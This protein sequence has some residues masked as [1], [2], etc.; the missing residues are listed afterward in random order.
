[1]N[2]KP[3]ISCTIVALMLVSILSP[4]VTASVVYGPAQFNRTG[5]GPDLA[6]DNFSLSRT[7]GNFSLFIKNGDGVENLTSSALVRLNG[8]TVVKTNEFNQ[9]VFLISKNI[10]VQPTN[11]LEVEVRSIPGSYI[12]L[13][14]EDE[15]PVINILSPWDDAVSNGTIK[16]SGNVTDLNIT[17]LTLNYNGNISAIPVVYGNFSST[18][19]LTGISNITLSAVDSVDMLRSAT[20]LLDGDMLPES[21]ERFLGFDPQN[22]DSDSALTPENEAGN[23]IIDGYETLGGQLP[24]FVKSRIGADPFKNDTDNDGLTDYFELMK[25]GLLT[26]VRS[27]DSDGD[28]IPDAE[29]DPDNDNLT[30]LQEQNYGTDPLVSD[31]D[32]DTLP[33]GFEINSGTNPLLKD[34]DN[35]RL[36]DGSE[37]RLGTNPLNADTDGDGILD[38]D[39]VYSSIKKDEALGVGASITGKGDMAKN[40]SIYN[41]ASEVFTNVSALVSPVIDF[42]LNGTFE[43]AEISLPYD[44][45]RVNNPSNISL[46]YFNESLGTFTRIE[47]RADTVNHTVTGNTSHLSTFA[48]L[49]IPAWDALFEAPM[50]IGYGSNVTWTVITD[51][52]NSGVNW[53]NGSASF[54]PGLYRMN[55]S[56]W[57]THWSPK[58]AVTKCLDETGD[59]AATIPAWCNRGKNYN[60]PDMGMHVRYGS[61]DSP[62]SALRVRPGILEFMH[63]GG[64]IGVWDK[65]DYYGDNSADARY[66]LEYADTDGDGLPDFTETDGFRDG[67][68]NLYKTDP[69]NP[70]TDGDGLSDGE[71]A[72]VLVEISGKRYFNIISKPTLV[73]SDHDGIADPDEEEFGTK[74]LDPDYDKDGLNDGF[75]L[76]IG[77]DPLIQDTDNDEYGDFEEHYDPFYD[78]LVYEK[79]Y[80]I[81]EISRDVV[82]GAVLGEWGADNNDSVYYMAG[83]MLSGFIV[84]G[85]IRDI[86]AS[87]ARGDGLGT[88][89]N[90]LALIPGYG[91]A[92]KV[93]VTISKFVAKHPN[94]M[95]SAASFA[96]KYIDDSIGWIKASIGEDVV[97]N[98]N[99][100]GFSDD[101]IIKLF[102][103]IDLKRFDDILTNSKIYQDFPG[104]PTFVREKLTSGSDILKDRVTFDAKK[105]TAADAA[106]RSTAGY[107]GNLK[108]AYTEYLASI[109]IGG[110]VVIGV[111]HVNKG[112]PDY[113]AMVGGDTLKIVEAKARQSLTLGNLDRYIKPNKLTGAL[114]FNGDYVIKD[115]GEDYFKNPS[116]KKQF[117]LYLNGPNSQAIKNSLNLPASLPYEFTRGTEKIKG[118]IEIVVIAVNK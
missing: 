19:N 99:N 76:E 104:L 70:D 22:P 2:Y 107:L 60:V 9:N 32:K 54:L 63:Q 72:G 33:D 75:E 109:D 114:E 16:V 95:F 98:L 25:L 57:Y 96:L 52:R 40:L 87:I 30:N 89:L 18:V 39:E 65:D 80:S 34:T 77:T 93:S 82:L 38:G 21:Q 112:G 35:D 23:G 94:M 27:G 62:V 91:D 28:G 110:T 47:S 10:S 67:L 56:G 37:I 86:A 101:V 97:K 7:D 100:K 92:A 113:V 11:G 58:P 13:W 51:N 71:E 17:N 59:E 105:M 45:Q 118:T 36:D 12:T 44:P 3:L 64:P 55:A 53:F 66:V 14:V 85:D 115:I 79:R 26:D 48:V 49:D 90:A 61:N 15:S 46:F 103:E 88:L 116:I 31:T 117:L 81:L 69:N 74:P 43:T 73:D 42:K 68:G 50:Y 29:E 108:G 8:E 111:K 5:G 41:V 78:P 102:K 106:G 4:A 24:A 1:M 6:Q 84:V 83:W 20:L